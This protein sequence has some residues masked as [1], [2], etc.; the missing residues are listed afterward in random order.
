MFS[1]GKGMI[2]NTIIGAGIGGVL[3]AAGGI[4]GGEAL[5]SGIE[6]LAQAPTALQYTVDV[7]GGVA[8]GVVGASIGG[9]IAQAGKLY[10]WVKG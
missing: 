10:K 1:E 5:N 4:F 6:Y 2:K 7:V 3:G 8:G 9:T